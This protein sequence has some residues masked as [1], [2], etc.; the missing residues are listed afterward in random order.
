MKQQDLKAL[1]EEAAN[2]DCSWERVNEIHCILGA[3]SPA[4]DS[5]PNSE[6][7]TEHDRGRAEGMELVLDSMYVETIK[8]RREFLPSLLPV[9]MLICGDRTEGS[10][11]NRDIDWSV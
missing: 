10:I 5:M 1:L 6:G 8:N 9:F 7:F 4:N 2:P 11:I 3:A